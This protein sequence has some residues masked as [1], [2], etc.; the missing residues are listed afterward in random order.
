VLGSPLLEFGDHVGDW[1]HTMVRFNN[2][3]PQAI[4]YSQHS[5]GEAFTYAATQKYQGGVRPV[6]YVANG[7]HANYAIS[8]IHD[9]TIP[10]LNLPGGPLEDHTD[11]GTF[12]DPAAN[13]YTYSFDTASSTFTAYNGQDPTGWLSFAGQWGDNE[14]PDGAPGQINIFGEKKYTAGPTGPEDKDLGRANVCPG[15]DSCT[16]LPVLIP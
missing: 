15:T 7:T 6:V 3:V 11:A 14:L 4:W 9:H 10:G 2:S 5:G 16:I 12:W 13:A 8:G 1:E